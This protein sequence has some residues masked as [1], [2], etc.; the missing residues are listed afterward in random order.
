MY[1]LYDQR[2]GFLDDLHTNVLG[3]LRKAAT[4]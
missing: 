1:V 2:R 3:V 4:S